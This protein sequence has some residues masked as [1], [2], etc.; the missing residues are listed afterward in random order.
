V[1]QQADSEYQFTRRRV[2]TALARL[3]GRNDCLLPFER[4]GTVVGIKLYGVKP[5]SLLGEAGIENGDLI[6]EVNGIST[7]TAQGGLRIRD[8]LGRAN[9][10]VVRLERDGRKLTFLYRITGG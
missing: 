6:L 1:S 3:D 7:A 10:F 9:R 2:N 5:D 4:E 8:E